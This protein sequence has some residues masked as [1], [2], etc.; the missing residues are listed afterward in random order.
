MPFNHF[1]EFRYFPILILNL[2]EFLYIN[3]GIPCNYS[4]KITEYFNEDCISWSWNQGTI[5]YSYYCVCFFLL[6]KGNGVSQTCLFL[7]SLLT[8]LKRSYVLNKIE[9]E[10]NTLKQIPYEL[11]FLHPECLVFS[12][13]YIRSN[14]TNQYWWDMVT[15]YSHSLRLVCL[16]IHLLKKSVWRYLK[17][18]FTLEIRAMAHQ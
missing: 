7:R 18:I 1:F 2:P 3:Y 10:I 13:N 11:Y 4:L 14:R 17:K 8:G 15:I 9:S 6:L 5:F 12:R 16:L